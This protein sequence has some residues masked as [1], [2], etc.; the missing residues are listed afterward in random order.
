MGKK[1]GHG[2]RLEEILTIGGQNFIVEIRPVRWW[3][4]FY[5]K[6]SRQGKHLKDYTLRAGAFVGQT[7]EIF[8]TLRRDK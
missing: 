4:R 8:W 1:V 6:Q 5:R 3:D 7:G 2:G